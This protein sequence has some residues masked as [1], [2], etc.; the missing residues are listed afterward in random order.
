[1]VQRVHQ[2]PLMCMTFHTVHGTVFETEKLTLD[3]TGSC[4]FYLD[5]TSF[6]TNVPALFQDPI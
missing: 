4:R 5:F 1:M 3:T 2:L 6:R